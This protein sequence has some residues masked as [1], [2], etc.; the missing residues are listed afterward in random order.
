MRHKCETYVQF[1]KNP[2]QRPDFPHR[3]GSGVS[4]DSVSLPLIKGPLHVANVKRIS[5]EW[6]KTPCGT[7]FR[8][9]AKC[10]F[11]L[12]TSNRKEEIFLCSVKYLKLGFVEWQA[13]N[14]VIVLNKYTK[15]IHCRI[16]RKRK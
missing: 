10:V 8:V 14:F 3:V 11:G 4:A 6:L 16:I 15:E 1:Y 9:T 5:L 2:L 12:L 13:F 7:G